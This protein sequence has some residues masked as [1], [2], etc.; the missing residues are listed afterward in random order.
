MWRSDTITYHRYLQSL[1]QLKEW[2]RQAERLD[3]D[4]STGPVTAR[5]VGILRR[6]DREIYAQTNREKTLDDVMRLLTASGQK[7][8]LKRFRAAVVE[9]MGKPADALS[10]GRLGLGD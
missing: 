5:A 8:N 6:L 4:S 3:V 9:V 2:G 10:H 1:E 7:V